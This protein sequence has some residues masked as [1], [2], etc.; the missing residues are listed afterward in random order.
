MSDHMSENTIEQVHKLDNIQRRDFAQIIQNE[1]YS[2]EDVKNAADLISKMLDWVPKNR[3]SCEK[4][5]Q[6][7]F[8]R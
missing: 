2:K 1:Q 4:A 6:H 3:I 5:L 7:K 8:L